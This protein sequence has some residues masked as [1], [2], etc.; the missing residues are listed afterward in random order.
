MDS[1][2]TDLAMCTFVKC[3]CNTASVLYEQHTKYLNDLLDKH[4]PEVSGTFIKDHAKSFALA[5]LSHLLA[6]A[7]RCQSLWR[8][9]K[10][11]ENRTRTDCPL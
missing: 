5:P 10:S 8:K 2:W 7:V 4:A 11:P 9:Y 1:F 6:K 3:R